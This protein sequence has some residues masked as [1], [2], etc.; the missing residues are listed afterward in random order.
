MVFLDSA[1]PA[2]AS[3]AAHLAFVAGVTTNPALVARTGGEPL[4][5]LAEIVQA[6][7]GGPVFFQPGSGDPAAAE[8]EAR[9]AV[10][11]APGR[12]VVKLLA[13]LELFALAARLGREGVPCAMTAVYAPAQALLAHAAGC[14]WVIPYVDRARRLMPEGP[15]LVRSLASVLG[16]S[17]GRTRILAASLKTA[18]QAAG[19]IADGAGA[20]TVPMDV[21]TSLAA[22]PLT[23]SAADEF[24]RAA[25]GVRQPR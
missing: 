6:F 11:V 25:R 1:D 20:V 17:R 7:P 8:A 2:E 10:E 21:L 15:D 14:A 9:A 13:R 3:A 16:P 24:T 18:D 12:I 19:A 22:H 4:G 23:E 5:V